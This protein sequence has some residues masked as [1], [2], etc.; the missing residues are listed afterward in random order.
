MGSESGNLQ[1]YGVD[2]FQS[3]PEN[4]QG[5]MWKSCDRQSVKNTS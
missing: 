3:I 4:T 1:A 2:S 5:C